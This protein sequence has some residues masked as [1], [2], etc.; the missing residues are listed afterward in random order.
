M[1]KRVEG[2]IF[3][4]IIGII[5]LNSLVGFVDAISGVSPAIYYEDFEP[6]FKKSFGFN[7]IFDVGVKAEIYVEGELSEYVRVNKKEINGREQ[8]IASVSLPKE[9]ERP[10]KNIIY[11]GARQLVDEEDGIGLAA[12]PRGVI[13]IKVP[14]P[15]K[16]AEASVS[17]GNAN[18]GELI[19]LVVDVSNLGKEDILASVSVETYGSVGLK[20]VLDLG[21]KEISSTKSS[22][23]KKKI[24]TNGYEAGDYFANVS[25]NYGGD[26]PALASGLFRI[27]KL[28]VG[29]GNVSSDFEKGKINRFIVPVE[30]F[31]NDAISGLHANVSFPGYDE[32]FLTPTI[33]IGPWQ[34]TQLTGFFDASKI[35]KEKFIANITLYYEGGSTNELV[36]VH[37]KKEVDYRMYIIIGG[38]VGVIL[39]LAGVIIFLMRK[40]G[41]KRK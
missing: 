37:F 41:K 13:V 16:Y 7:F 25:V 29:I 2:F 35:D 21:S 8:V 15:G 32:S 10:G 34:K 24:D 31:W 3:I 5:I 28:Y 14:Y 1:I 12:N 11:I 6:N 4:L 22:S 38:L 40:N 23:F 27:G 20:E 33:E 26:K 17:V 30:S 9:L 36:E 19:D 39:V 18:P